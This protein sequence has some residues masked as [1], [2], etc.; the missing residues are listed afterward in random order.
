MADAKLLIDG[1]EHE[2]P[3]L[4]TFDMDEYQILFDLSG[5]TVAD[6]A[7]EDDDQI[8]RNYWNPGYQRALLVVAYLRTHPGTKRADVEKLIGKVRLAD[9]IDQGVDDADPPP[10]SVQPPEEV[11]S[12]SKSAQSGDH[13]SNGSDASPAEIPET[14]GTG[15]SD[16]SQDKGRELLARGSRLT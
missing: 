16:T 8:T 13:S 9:V 7:T 5:L 12:S 3:A 2:V 6:F 11:G 14:T 15:K 10:Q 4:S 1:V